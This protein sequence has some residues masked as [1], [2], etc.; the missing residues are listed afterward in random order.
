MEDI[1]QLRAQTGCGI[2]DCKE[3][4]QESDGNMEKAIAWLRERGKSKAAKKAARATHEG[5]IGW[6]VHGNNKIA[7]MVALYCETDFVARNE[8][9]QELARGIAM[10]VAASDPAVIKP[11]DMPA[12]ELQAERE[13][14][15]KQAAGDNKPAE[16]QEKIIEGKLKK[17][18][19]ERAL[20]TQPYVKDASKTVGAFIE[21]H[22]QELGENISVGEFN[23]LY[24]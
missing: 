5:A 11:E 12:E 18:S 4:L 2:V 22:I 8:K 21:E 13:I 1:K 17:F 16:I 24:I 3:A 6:Y 14:A 23:R 7:A 9:F 10:H 15:T 19:E 20:L